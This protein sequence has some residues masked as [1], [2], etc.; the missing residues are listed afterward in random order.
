MF[1]LL[2]TQK[3]YNIDSGTEIMILRTFS[4]YVNIKFESQGNQTLYQV[5]SEI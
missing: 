4:H 3:V 1:K 2:G 5:D